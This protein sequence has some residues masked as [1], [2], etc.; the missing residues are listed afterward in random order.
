MVLAWKQFGVW[1]LVWGGIF[2]TVLGVF[3]L[4]LF[5]PVRPWFRFD[6]ALTREFGSFGIKFTSNELVSYVR[7]QIPNFVLG[8]LAGPSVVGLFNKADS[9][10]KTPRIV[11]GS[12]YDPIFRSLAKNQDNADRSR[13][14]YL[15]TVMLL[16]VYMMPLF[17]GLAWLAQ[18][19]IA[20]VYGPKWV[21]SATPLAILSLVGPFACIEFPAGAVLAARSWLGREFFVQLTR[22]ALYA[23][24]ATIGIRWGLTGV[25]WG[26][27]LADGWTAI[28]M[29]YLVMRCLRTTLR[30]LAPSL[31]PGL[32]LNSVLLGTLLVMDALLPD[33]FGARR[34]FTYM[35]T[36][37]ASGGLTYAGAFLLLLPFVAFTVVPFRF[38]RWRAR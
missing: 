3:A 38:R 12:V 32:L 8:R 25:A 1:S 26:I 6:A 27:L 2:G 18:P 17:V 29:A 30:Q 16:S 4:Y 31:V 36:M 28:A 20:F 14:I 24:A 9:L 21:A 35:L 5:T 34:P 23:A 22:A 15:R 7:S 37:A 33:G 10:A 19:F 11:A 13:Y